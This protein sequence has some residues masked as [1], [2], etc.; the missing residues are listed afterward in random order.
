MIRRLERMPEV[1][2]VEKNYEFTPALVPDD[3]EYSNQWHLPQILADQAWDLTQGGANA[4]IAILD[5]GVDATHPDLAGKLVD[6]YNTYSNNTDTTDPYGHGTKVAGVAGAATNNAE[7]VAGVAGASPIMPVR[8]TNASGAATSASIADGIT[9]AADHG[10]RVVNLS[11]NGVAGDA[12]I[13]T[14]AE[15][16]F[17]H[18]TLV[19]AASGNCA[20]ADPT[21]E[22]PFMLSVSA[23]DEND[24]LAYFS[25]TGPYVDLS[26]PGTN[27]LTTDLFGTYFAYSGTS[28]ASPVVAG[29]AALMYSANSSLTPTLVTQLLEASVVDLGSSGYDTGFGFGRVDALAAVTLAMSYTPPA[30]LTAPTISMTVPESG[31]TVSGTVVV[32]VTADDD[33]G[34]VKVDL[35]VDDAFFDSVAE[36]PYSFAWDTIALPNGTHTLQAMAFDAAGNSAGT[37][38][39]SVTVSNTPPDITPPIVSIDAPAA[40]ATVYGT[41]TVTA[42]ATD[43]IGVVSTDLYVDGALYATDTTA[44]YAFSWNT[45]ASANCSH[46]L[47]VVAADAAGNSSHALRTVTVANHVHHAPVAVNDV[48]TAPYR[49]KS[50]YTAQVFAVLANDSDAD[51]NLNRASVK[52]T[53]SP[54]KGGTATVRANG[55][56]AYKPRIGFRGVETFRYTVKDKLGGNIQY[57]DGDGH[58]SLSEAMT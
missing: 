48:F 54:N 53:R 22:T 8:V 58:R 27:I 29:V 23:T 21:A 24:G 31:A 14:A 4:V 13:R 6:G 1:K 2:F 56:V 55:R 49:A 37:I 35:Y 44:P 9:W 20:C 47:D 5:S 19:V 38:P 10:A 52:I 50:S 15:Y 16:A 36:T 57:R 43:D 45:T 42:T 3:P 18:G 39:V 28:Q 12:A 11:F 17:N 7:G 33:V 26:A 25:S 40:G 46:T 32:D 34:V 30:D 41:A 51:G